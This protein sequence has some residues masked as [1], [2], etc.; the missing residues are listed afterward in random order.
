M[1]FQTICLMRE[2]TFLVP[3]KTQE[4]FIDFITFQYLHRILKT[5]Q[6]KE[7][8]FRSQDKIEFIVLTQTV[9]NAIVVKITFTQVR[10]VHPLGPKHRTKMFLR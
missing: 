1:N 8:A 6:R 2:V 10:G 5:I 7:V 3:L 9:I 4:K